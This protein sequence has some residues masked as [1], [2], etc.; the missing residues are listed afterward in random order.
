MCRRDF[1]LVKK[2]PRTFL[3]TP[4]SRQKM[5]R[6]S[7]HFRKSLGNEAFVVGDPIEAGLCPLKLPRCLLVFPA[8]S[9]GF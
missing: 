2:A 1:Q 3:T 9:L 4:K 6:A 8:D 7:V 5:H